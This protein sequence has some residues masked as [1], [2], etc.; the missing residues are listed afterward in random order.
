MLFDGRQPS[1]RTQGHGAESAPPTVLG[2]STV[3]PI[4]AR[5]RALQE[6]HLRLLQAPLQMPGGQAHR[7]V[8]R[9]VQPGRGSWAPFSGACGIGLHATFRTTHTA[10]P[11]CAHGHRALA[12]FLPRPHARLPTRPQARDWA[13]L[14]AAKA[15]GETMT[16]AGAAGWRATCGRDV[17]GADA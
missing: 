10:C 9:V 8:E 7:G 3:S 6:R 13:P 2:D 17:G 15:V 5:A 1:G 12:R 14:L 16:H 4:H 11:A